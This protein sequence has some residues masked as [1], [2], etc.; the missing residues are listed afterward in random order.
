MS[1]TIIRLA[2]RK[3]APVAPPPAPKRGQFVAQIE[4]LT[5]FLRQHRPDLMRSTSSSETAQ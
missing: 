2:D 3:P 4:E 1:A 5:R